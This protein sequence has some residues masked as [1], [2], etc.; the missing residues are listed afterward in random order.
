MS[1]ADKEEIAGDGYRSLEEGQKLEF[2][3]TQGQKG[4]QAENVRVTRPRRGQGPFPRAPGS[5]GIPGMWTG[6]APSPVPNRVAGEIFEGARIAMFQQRARADAD[7]QP[8]R[9][10]GL[11]RVA[12]GTLCATVR[13]GPG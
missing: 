10:T 13:S 2:D 12:A 4:P 7:R 8:R 9:R 11:S 6:P 5:P 1:L 3:I